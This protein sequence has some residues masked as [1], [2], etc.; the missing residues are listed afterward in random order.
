[1][2]FDFNKIEEE[3]RDENKELSENRSLIAAIEKAL[4]EGKTPI[5]AEAKTAGPKTGKI[6]DIEQE[7]AA[8][9]LEEGGACAISILT[10]Q[11][12]EG[13][14][15][16][17]RRTK[18]QTKIPVLRKDF[19]I[20]EFQLYESCGNGANAVLLIASLLKERTKDFVDKAH[21]LG[22]EAL[23]E[24]HNEEDLEYALETDAKLI[25]INNRDLKTLET[26]L[27]TTERLTQKIPKNKIIVSESGI[28][29]KEDIIRLK[30]AG[31][32]AFLIG[33]GIMT[34]KNIKEKTRELVQ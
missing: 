25:G 7:D 18:Q 11:H 23:V 21:K 20:E 31:A 14:I 13:K 5:I 6:S 2:K 29:T 12:F 34:G 8:K 33:T 30:K 16:H 32:K 26:E 24:I 27:G 3:K 10:D 17:L 28:K 1:M 4:R 22:M 9:L 19:I 15:C